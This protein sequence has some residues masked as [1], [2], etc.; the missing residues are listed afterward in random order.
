VRLNLIVG[1]PTG[2]YRGGVNSIIFLAHTADITTG[3]GL[4]NEILNCL[5]GLDSNIWAIFRF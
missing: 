2:S 1:P 4:L 3:M 5:Q